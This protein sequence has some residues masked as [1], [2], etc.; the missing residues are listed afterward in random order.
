M[1][2]F[3]ICI[4]KQNSSTLKILQ[5]LSINQQIYLCK[6]SFVWCCEYL[7]SQ[8]Q[9]HWINFARK[10]SNKL[11]AQFISTLELFY[12]IW[13]AVRM[14][15][16]FRFSCINQMHSMIFKWTLA[17]KHSQSHSNENHSM[18]ICLFSCKYFK[19]IRFF[20]RHIQSISNVSNLICL[21]SIFRYF[22]KFHV[23]RKENME[24]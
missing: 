18:E 5:R 2:V 23:L 12:T 13:D 1:D 24:I 21:Q 22:T 10:I 14:G 20:H 8:V 15:C 4:T 6:H 7:Q 9:S 19:Q 3:F 11:F 16:F 17:K